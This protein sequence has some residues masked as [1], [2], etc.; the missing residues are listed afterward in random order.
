VQLLHYHLHTISHLLVVTSNDHGFSR[1]LLLLTMTQPV[2]ISETTNMI[3]HTYMPGV[4]TYRFGL[5]RF[6][7][8]R[9]SLQRLIP[10]PRVRMVLNG[11]KRDSTRPRIS[12]MDGRGVQDDQTR[13]KSGPRLR[14]RRR[15]SLAARVLPLFSPGPRVIRT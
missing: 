8:V 5:V 14:G 15:R 1:M 11:Q 13:P 4:P 10:H 12:N 7:L 6:G 9:P 2:T 3:F